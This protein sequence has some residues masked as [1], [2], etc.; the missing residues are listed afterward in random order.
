MK[1]AFLQLHASVFLAGFTGILG[2]LIDLN[3]G[4]LVWYRLLLASVAMW[5]LVLLTGKLQKISLKDALRLTGIGFLAAIHWVTFYGSIKY[6]N[7]SVALVCFSSI[8]FFTSLA[9]PILLRTKIIWMEVLLGILVIAGI[10]IIFHFDPKYKV[11][12]ILGLICALLMSFVIIFIRQFVQRINAETLLTYQLSGGLITLSLLIPFYLKLFPTEY[13]IPDLNDWLWLLVLALFCSVLAFML[14]VNALKKLSAF[15]VN[16]SF[17]LEP[18]YGILLA[19][20]FFGENKQLGWSFLA[21]FAL[22]SLSL[23]IH[24]WM[25][26]RQQRKITRDASTWLPP[27][28]N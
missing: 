25:L 23:I 4:L 27:K 18:V 26:I 12:I 1:K 22:I 11:G 24:A 21:G 17:N 15:T 19:F 3:E 9:E 8:G 13:I 28:N 16:L 7:V 5:I 20:I 10:F 2:L 14:S 6:A